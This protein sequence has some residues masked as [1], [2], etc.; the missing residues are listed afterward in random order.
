[1]IEAILPVHIAAGGIAIVAGYIALFAGKGRAVHRKSGRVFVYAMV[2]MVL[3]AALIYLSRGQGSNAIS[4]LIA[5]YL[6]FTGLT[7]V[8]PLG[9]RWRWV[10][11]AGLVV[12]ASVALVSLLGGMEAMRLGGVREGVPAPMLFLFMAVAIL[13][14]AGDIRIIRSGPLTGSSRLA[15]HFWRMCYSLWIATG[16]FFIGQADELPALLQHPAYYVPP[17]VAPL[18]ALFYWLWRVRLKGSLRGLWIGAPT[19]P[20]NQPAARQV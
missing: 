6:A 4:A 16:S 12:V 13:A 10:G 20:S 14:G 5:P 7:T 2:A 11:S 9:D 17:A 19:N 1:M 15:R 3:F 8:R 18:I